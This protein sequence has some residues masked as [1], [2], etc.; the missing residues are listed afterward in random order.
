MQFGSFEILR[1]LGRGGMAETFLAI[2]RGPDGFERQV[3]LKRVLAERAAEPDFVR[4]FQREAR[5]ASRLVHPHIAQ[6]Y[7]FGC[8]EGVWWM[9]LEH[10]PGGDVRTLLRALGQPMPVELGLV[11]AIDVLEALAVAHEAGIVHRDV[12]PS[13]ILLDL[14]GHFKLADFGIAKVTHSD[15]TP[16]ETGF[17]TTTGTVKGKAAYMA[18]EQALGRTVDGRA[19]LWALG[20]VLFEAFACAK[21]FEG[22]TDLA[23]MMAASQ[24]RRAPLA[25]RAPHVPPHVCAVVERLLRPEP[26]ER[27]QHAAD[28]L[29]AL[30]S[31]PPSLRAR[32][33]LAE[34]LVAVGAASPTESEAAPTVQ[35]PALPDEAREPT[36]EPPQRASGP[37]AT[38]SIRRPQRAL[39][40]VPLVGLAAVAALGVFVSVRPVGT[41]S[42]STPTPPLHAE[43][44]AATWVST[45]PP[46]PAPTLDDL[47]TGVIAPEGGGT[48]LVGATPPRPAVSPP[49]R[50]APARGPGP[51]T[52]EPAPAPV[53]P[54]RPR[55]SLRVTVIPW[56]DVV[57]DGRRA[58]R[59]PLVLD[60][61][62]GPHRVEISS[63]SGTRLRTV[64]VVAGDRVELEEDLTASP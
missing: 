40:L 50:P 3:C 27:Y 56:G 24:G 42:T 43:P 20:V 36:V 59:S 16:G 23:I 30:S 1:P 51:L 49:P 21:P 60:L 11:L 2:R 18:P 9:S 10:V 44:P 35:G 5:V 8:H 29:E 6:V 4:S 33:R 19:D 63:E 31:Q 64:H 17:S 13:N 58:G 22:P 57:V 54:A 62:E 53:E 25:E 38:S 48:A 15:R 37:A 12:S 46:A 55:G 61:D 34:L 45:P 14:Q 28:V 32:R 7:E 41:P 26:S 47:P 39:L 52:P